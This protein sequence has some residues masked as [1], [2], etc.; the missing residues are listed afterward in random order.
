MRKEVTMHKE[1]RVTPPDTLVTES[2]TDALPVTIVTQSPIVTI[3][4]WTQSDS[5][6]DQSQSAEWT[7]AATK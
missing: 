2:A 4:R 1:V 7:P 5:S 3:C 6:S